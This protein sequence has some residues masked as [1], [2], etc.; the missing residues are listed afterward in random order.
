MSFKVVAW[1]LEHS[2]AEKAC[3]LLVMICIAQCANHDGSEAFP[4]L[5]TLI[6]E[7]RQSRRTVFAALKR[8]RELGELQMEARY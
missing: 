4:E 3:D 8:L 1:V 7:S 5:D 2:K 6:R